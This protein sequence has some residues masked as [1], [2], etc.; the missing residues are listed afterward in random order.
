M[1][2]FFLFI[3]PLQQVWDKI[4]QTQI[5]PWER[6]NTTT[7]QPPASVVELEGDC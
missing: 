2:F 4:I 7:K 5:I 6:S 1:I 3:L